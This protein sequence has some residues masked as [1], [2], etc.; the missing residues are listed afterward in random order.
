MAVALAAAAAPTSGRGLVSFLSNP[1]LVT[2]LL[3]EARTHPAGVFFYIKT[4]I[5]FDLSFF[6]ATSAPI[7]RIQ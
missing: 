4:V 6:L 1:Y 7:Q 3:C 5:L 2:E